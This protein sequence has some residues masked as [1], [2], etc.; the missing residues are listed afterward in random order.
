MSTVTPTTMAGQMAGP[1]SIET[2]PRIKNATH[3]QIAP[4]MPLTIVVFKPAVSPPFAK[5]V[6]HPM[7]M[8]QICRY[9]GNTPSAS[10]VATAPRTPMLT[11]N[12]TKLVI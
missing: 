7:K 12:A 1:R 10:Q 6:A 3:A 9:S 8:T 11:D 4:Q 2:A 5:Y